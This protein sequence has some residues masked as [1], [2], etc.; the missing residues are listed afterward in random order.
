L[1]GTLAAANGGTGVNNGS[2]TITLGGNLAF[3]GAFGTTFTVAGTTALTLPASGTVL[4]DG[5]VVDGGT[6]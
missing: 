5:S 3:S 2:S 1:A 4:S 6:F